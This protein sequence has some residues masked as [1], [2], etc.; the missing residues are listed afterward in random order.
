MSGSLYL[1]QNINSTADLASFNKK[2]LS[3]HAAACVRL[4]RHRL[5]CLG[6]KKH[7]NSSKTT[8]ALRWQHAQPMVGA[9]TT[10]LTLMFAC[11]FERRAP[12]EY[13][14]TVATHYEVDIRPELD[15][16]IVERHYSSSS[17]TSL[18]TC[19]E[20]PT[21]PKP[22]ASRDYEVTRNT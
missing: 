16:F 15:D 13:K 1:T 21:S 22:M 5:S 3:W 19:I 4:K 12:L 6:C 2:T 11:T 7:L 14:F 8:T 18:S 10:N 17:C 20:T 9:L